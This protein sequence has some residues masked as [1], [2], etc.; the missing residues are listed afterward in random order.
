MIIEEDI[1]EEDENIFM[2]WYWDCSFYIMKMGIEI[3]FLY[4]MLQIIL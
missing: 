3:E 4:G 2:D 1:A